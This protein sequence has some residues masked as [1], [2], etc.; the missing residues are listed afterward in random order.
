MR[1]LSSNSEEDGA[2]QVQG[3]CAVEF[4]AGFV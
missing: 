2:M 1:L 3:P 4:T